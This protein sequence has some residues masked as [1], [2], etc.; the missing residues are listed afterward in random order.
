MFQIEKAFRRSFL[1]QNWPLYYLIQGHMSFTEQHCAWEALD[2]DG[3][4]AHD[5]MRCICGKLS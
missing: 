3:S 2:L 5:L 1:T 4:D